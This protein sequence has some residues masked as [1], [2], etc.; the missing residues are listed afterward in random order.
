MALRRGRRGWR[1]A[2]HIVLAR[3][4]PVIGV[5]YRPRADR[6]RAPFQQLLE[7]GAGEIGQ[8]GGQET[9]QPPAG[10]IVARLRGAPIA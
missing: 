7:P 1:H 8:G 4:D 10:M 9:V 3:F 6:D 5:F 2:H